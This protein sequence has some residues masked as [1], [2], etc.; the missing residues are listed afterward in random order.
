[1]DDFSKCSKASFIWACF[2]GANF[3]L[4]N[5]HLNYMNEQ[6][7]V[8]KSHATTG[9]DQSLVS[10]PPTHEWRKRAALFALL[11]F[12]KYKINIKRQRKK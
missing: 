3:A 1:L 7:E 10:R 6:K 2:V 8:G 11:Y 5:L 9:K 12:K 4:D